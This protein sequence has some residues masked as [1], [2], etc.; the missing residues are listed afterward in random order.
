MRK[1]QILAYE[2]GPK[3][4]DNGNLPVLHRFSV[5]EAA[6]LQEFLESG[7]APSDNRLLTK[8]AIAFAHASVIVIG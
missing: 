4:R 7:I 5:D 3:E 1:R 8:A 2:L 6:Q